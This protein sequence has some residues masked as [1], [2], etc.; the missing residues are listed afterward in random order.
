MAQLKYI[1][2]LEFILDFSIFYFLHLSIARF[3]IES[4]PYYVNWSK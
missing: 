3:L 4:F 1:P 2:F